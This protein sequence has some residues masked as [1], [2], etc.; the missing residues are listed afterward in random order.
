[1]F[2]FQNTRCAFYKAAA[3]AVDD[4]DDDA[5]DV[6]VDLNDEEDEDYVPED[7]M[8]GVEEPEGGMDEEVK[9][10]EEEEEEEDEEEEDKEEGQ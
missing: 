3:A 10:E 8:E 7:E 1:M 9:E 5:I 6:F 2:N 4:D